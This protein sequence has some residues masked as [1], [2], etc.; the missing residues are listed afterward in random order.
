MQIS[1]N[2][3]IAGL[4]AVRVRDFFRRCN[5]GFAPEYASEFFNLPDTA[6]FLAEIET[7]GLVVN[8]DG[9]Y[10]LT[11]GGNALAIARTRTIHR[12]T[13]ERA[14]AG[15]IKRTNQINKGPFAFSV[16][17]VAVF[18][19]FLSDEDRL[20]DL[21]VGVDL[22][23]KGNDDEHRELCRQR[24]VEAQKAGRTFALFIDR[25]FWPREEVL[26][27]LKNRSPVISIHDFDDITGLNAPHRIV[28]PE[29]GGR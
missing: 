4:P 17:R 22:H 10:H 3:T 12:A 7:L 29:G 15:L 1:K 11:V 28:F 8:D 9:F 14:L 6:A 25:C 5:G 13:A 18:G 23:R 21:D 24:V 2:H 16:A 20:G 26:R 19:S 27:K